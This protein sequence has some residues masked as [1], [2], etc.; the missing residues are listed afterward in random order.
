[1][2]AFDVTPPRPLFR[3]AYR[4][5][6]AVSAACVIWLVWTF[7][8]AQSGEGDPSGGAQSLFMLLAVPYAPALCLLIAAA[9]LA[10]RR[11]PAPAMLQ[12]LAIANA[13]WCVLLTFAVVSQ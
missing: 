8:A 1:M 11:Q 5:A 7:A 3:L 12:V 2:T 4:V 9:W 13:G 6:M 10:V